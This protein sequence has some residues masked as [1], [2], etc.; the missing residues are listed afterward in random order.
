MAPF[1][2]MSWNIGQP[3]SRSSWLLKSI[4]F[5]NKGVLPAKYL[6]FVAK[7]IKLVK[8]HVVCLQEVRNAKD[9]PEGV[10]QL[11]ILE[12]SL[13]GYKG[14]YGPQT[15]GEHRA[16][17]VSRKF[18]T[19]HGFEVEEIKGKD[20]VGIAAF[21]PKKDAWIAN[22]HLDYEDLDM[23]HRQYHTLLSW[24]K[25]KRSRIILGGDYNMRRRFHLSSRHREIVQNFFEK[26]RK[27]SL[28]DATSKVG[29]TFYWRNLGIQLDHFFT[30]IPEWKKEKVYVLEGKRKSFMDHHP[31]VAEFFLRKE[32]MKKD[33]KRRI[34]RS[35]AKRAVNV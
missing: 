19:D 1:R 25:Q 16:L 21:L 32:M 12:K 11:K 10:D 26:M 30:N 22:V 18:T 7:T 31:V 8:P 15:D 20:G 5:F 14:F 28:R 17:L 4:P 27:H 35:L 23:R 33:L 3:Y 34:K 13:K 2:V 9:H 29:G 6:P 24:I